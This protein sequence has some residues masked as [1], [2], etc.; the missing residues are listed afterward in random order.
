[1][2]EKSSPIIVGLSGGADSICLAS[3]LKK[4]GYDVVVAHINHNLRKDE[5]IRDEKFVRDFATENRMISEILSVDIEKIS[6]DKKISCEMAGR[7]VRYNFFEELSQKY[8]TKFIAVAHNMNDNAET[9]LMNVI[10]GASINGQKGIIPVN[11]KIKRPLLC[12][13]RE[14]IELYLKEMS[15][16]YVNDSTNSEDIYT[17]NF[18][19]NQIIPLVK[20][21]N[22]NIIETLSVNSKLAFY[23]NEYIQLVTDDIYKKICQKTED[24]LIIDFTDEKMHISLKR[25]IIKKA[26]EEITDDKK[27]IS[28]INIEN[29][30]NLKPEKSFEYAGNL[31][32]RNIYGKL[33]FVLNNEKCEFSYVVHDNTD[34]FI[35]EINKTLRFEICENYIKN[36]NIMCIDYDKIDG[37][38]IIRSR[39]IGDKFSPIG[40]NGTQT[41]K[42]YFINKK[43]PSFLRDKIPI[44]TCN[45]KIIG[46]FPDRIDEKFAIT[47][48]TKKILTIKEI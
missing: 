9:I 48:N 47:E 21:I 42:D 24:G 46:V 38:I 40:L 31:T 5:A 17:R 7:N 29:I 32:I 12:V 6:K 23:D 15:I 45:N 30:L 16:S 3:L 19:R 37:E 8:H 28:F 25:R 41:V 34:I 27:R 22:P 35:K 18:V 26:L 1:M 10:Q 11:G 39:K 33:W 2:F 20:K 13:T 14:E 4:F 44:I 43:I 36:F